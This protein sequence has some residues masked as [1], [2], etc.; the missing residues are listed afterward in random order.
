M[1]WK[2]RE[3]SLEK[4]RYLADKHQEELSNLILENI[5]TNL[6]PIEF[7]KAKSLLQAKL[8]NTRKDLEAWL[9]TPR[10]FSDLAA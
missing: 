10:I 3:L 6:D 1:H 4:L 8:N 2:H 5:R 9:D 7:Y